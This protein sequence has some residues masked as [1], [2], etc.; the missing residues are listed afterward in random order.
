[1]FAESV[2]EESLKEPVVPAT[3]VVETPV[4]SVE[5]RDQAKP[6]AVMAEPLSLLT[7]PNIV[8]LTGVKD[9][10]ESVVTVGGVNAVIESTWNVP[11]VVKVWILYMP[12][13]VSVPPVAFISEST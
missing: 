9:W 12:L 2:V 6:R 5:E 7:V 10:A 11:D 13:V 4:A 8:A 1:V 3:V